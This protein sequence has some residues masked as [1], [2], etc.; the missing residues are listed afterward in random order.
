MIT[1]AFGS[2]ST[3]LQASACS[4]P[5]LDLASRGSWG[6]NI[7]HIYEGA[8][9]SINMDGYVDGQLVT[10][11]DFR[12]ILDRISDSKKP[13]VKKPFKGGYTF[14]GLLE[15]YVRFVVRRRLKEQA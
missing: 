12:S 10:V 15:R 4:H 13:W 2:H 6:G 1:Y 9:F 5:T 14:W 8:T 3:F 7:L 11:I